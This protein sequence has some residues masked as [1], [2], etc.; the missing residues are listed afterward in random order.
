MRRRVAAHR[1]P[2]LRSVDVNLLARPLFLV[3]WLAAVLVAPLGT[4]DEAALAADEAGG[5]RQ[6]ATLN[7][8]GVRLFELGKY[9]EALARFRQALELSPASP[10]I[11]TNLGKAHAA[12][13]ITML[14]E[15]MKAGGGR[16]VHRR[17]LEQ[18]QLAFVHWEGDADAWHAAGYCH[19]ELRE[20]ESACK[21][22]SEAVA[23]DPKAFRSWR[24]LGVAQELA[25]RLDDAERAYLRALTLR[26]GDADLEQR[27]HRLRCDREALRSYRVM[28]TDRS[29][30]HYP[31]T[32]VADRVLEVKSCL[33]AVCTEME[34]RWALRIPLPIVVICYPPGEFAART[35]LAKEVG[36]AFDGKIRVA[37]PADLA[38]GG[39]GLEQVVRHEAVHLLLRATGAAP[40]RWIDEGLAQLFDGD[41][42]E[43]W[44]ARWNELRAAEPRVGILERQARFR[45]DDPTTWV[46]L[47]LHSFFLFRHLRARG[48]EFRLDL[49][50]REVGRGRSWEEAIRTVYSSTIE[51]LDRH[52]RGSLEEAR[53]R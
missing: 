30:I 53:G 9:Q 49:L 43:D 4:P 18:L 31:E 45:E 24:L 15:G 41:P 11:R 8:D 12:I 14:D 7:D 46:P 17:A 33:E 44:H 52:W 37:F 21:A 25:N 32:L 34:R 10:E 35:G 39:L 50:V 28:T 3:A 5:P 19:L 42:R 23:R 16:P 22:L 20:N 13:G 51:E 1:P 48:E 47:Y 29:R 2:R 36:G 6:A 38:A 27:L 26:A 40:P